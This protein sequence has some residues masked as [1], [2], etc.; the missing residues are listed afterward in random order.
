MK[1]IIV[2]SPTKARTFNKLVDQKKYLVIS[3][4]GHILDLPKN[5]LGI[6]ID[7]SFKPEYVP[8]ENKKK[9][10]K[11]IAAAAKKAEEI[12]LATDPDREGEA[13]AYHLKKILSDKVNKLKFSRIVFHEI[14][15][16][17]LLKALSES[18]QI[19]I[20][21]FDAQQARRI[22]DRIFG[23]QLSP[24]LWKKFSKHWL[25]AGR[26]QSV[27]L[28]FLVEREKERLS[29]RAKPIYPIKALFRIKEQLPQA[30]LVKLLNKNY[31]QNQSLQLF[32]GK[33]EYQTT[34][35]STD[36]E[37]KKH[38]T[39]LL[40]ENYL[41]DKIEESSSTRLPPPPFTTSTLQQYGSSY[42]GYSAK[43]TM[44][45]AQQL[46]EHGLIT[47]HRTD[48]NYLSTGFL[49][50]ARK[51]IQKNYGADYLAEKIR[52]YKTK[53]KLAQEAHEAIRPTKIKNDQKATVI[54]KLRAD[55][56]KLYSAI[57]N[58]ALA[59]QMKAAV[60]KN[61]KII[62]VSGSADQFVINKQ[63]IIFSGFLILNLSKK[64]ETDLFYDLKPKT[65]L[66]LD[67]LEIEQ[68][69]TL[70]PPRYN[71]AMLIKTLEARGIGRPSTYAPIVSLILERH[72]ANK[73]GR[74]LVPSL[75]G[76]KVNE[77]LTA[78][79]TDLLHP[80]F[81]A[82]MEDELDL[83]ALGKKEWPKVV[84]SYYVPFKN[85]LEKAGKDNSKIR[86]EEKT[87]RKCPKCG[88]ELVIRISRYGKFYACSNFPKCRYTENFTQSL[89][90]PCPKCKTG[91]L[92]IRY[93]KNKKRFYACSNYPKCDYTS[94]W[95]PKGSKNQSQSQ[96]K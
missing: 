36:A 41:I 90:I 31:F 72:Y 34:L 80:T 89:N 23:Y 44:S 61:Q 84:E 53:S 5:K 28:R 29:F 17:A 82:Q 39:R 22:L 54:K 3:S 7:N 30:K 4:M 92:V 37:K 43:R 59:T 86:I 46:Y 60:L 66:V 11:E 20:H 49:S 63:K 24:Y 67:K 32:D 76:I 40:K 96:E 62:I 38:E 21:L 6:D 95:L 45:L 83:I 75:L 94:L 12:I 50:E 56:F 16:E 69:L 19:N 57:Y 15:K 33:Y 42:L 65:N 87:G 27:A 2:E 26:V 55:Q 35:I 25:S 74:E 18:K 85:K 13:I 52:H 64:D 9:L 91:H 79:F 8:L 88:R 1:L 14:T 10:I 71:E 51:Y 81:T 70:P 47:Y 93:S 58:R 78:S 68:K 48:S 77:L 73:E